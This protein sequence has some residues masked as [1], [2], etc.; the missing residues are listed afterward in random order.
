ME[1]YVRLVSLEKGLPR[2]SATSAPRP[3]VSRPPVMSLPRSSTQYRVLYSSSQLFNH[4][5]DLS[6][7]VASP[8]EEPNCSP[9]PSIINPPSPSMSS[10][11]NMLL[12]RTPFATSSNAARLSVPHHATLPF[13]AVRRTLRFPPRPPAPVH[14]S[15]FERDPLPPPSAMHRAP[16]GRG[17][18]FFFNTFANCFAKL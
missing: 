4:V 7:T 16:L 9:S 2:V 1:R 3:L 18:D 5:F 14:S 8:Q 10:R 15:P 12:P 13:P 11:E 17:F 6:L